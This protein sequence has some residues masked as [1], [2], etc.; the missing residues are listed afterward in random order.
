MGMMCHN[1][2]D[3]ELFSNGE[4]RNGRVLS[5]LYSFCKI[6]YWRLVVLGISNKIMI[7]NLYTSFNS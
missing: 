7:N 2:D 3:V 5:L 4:G 6:L 1:G